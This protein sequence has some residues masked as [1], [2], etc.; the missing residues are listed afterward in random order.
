M[1]ECC[2][3]NAYILL[4]FVKTGLSVREGSY[5]SQRIALAKALI[6]GFSSGQ[7]IGHTPSVANGNLERL[8]LMVNSLS[9]VTL[10]PVALYVI[11]MA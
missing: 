4:S 8:N 10:K 2:V 9:V 7:Q 3:L 11:T 1:I 6:G 5:L